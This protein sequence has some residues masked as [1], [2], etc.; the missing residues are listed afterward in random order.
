M[1]RADIIRLA[2]KLG[3]MDLQQHHIDSNDP[4]WTLN[5]SHGA[6]GPLNIIFIDSLT[7]CIE[8][9]KWYTLH[10]SAD[11]KLRSWSEQ[12]WGSAC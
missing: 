8:S 3:G 10:F 1:P 4:S 11:W 9:G 7:F 5:L 6:A 2:S 12:P